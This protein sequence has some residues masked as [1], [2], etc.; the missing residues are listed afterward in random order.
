MSGSIVGRAFLRLT[1][2]RLTGAGASKHCFTFVD[3]EDVEASRQGPAS[4]QEYLTLF[5]ERPYIS[6]AGP[7]TEKQIKRSFI[8][9]ARRKSEEL[10]AVLVLSIAYRE[11]CGAGFA[12]THFDI[13]I[14]KS[15]AGMQYLDSLDGPAT[16]T[17]EGSYGS[18][19]FLVQGNSV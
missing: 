16:A 2:G 8:D 6:H 11:D 4:D 19:T 18:N 9:L 5:L 7:E 17:K 14:S 10:G 12:Q 13:Y 15:K 3:L 1:K